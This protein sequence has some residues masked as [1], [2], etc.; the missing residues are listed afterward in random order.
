MRVALVCHYLMPHEGGI[1]RVVDRLGQEYRA[2]GCTTTVVGFG[3][4][5]HATAPAGHTRQALRGWN[6]LE[7]AGIPVPLVAPASSWLRLRQV[8]RDVDAV[9][10][11]GLLHPASTMA[12]VQCRR[13][14]L[15][16]VLTEHVGTVPVKNQLVEATQTRLIHATARMA[17][18]SVSALTVLNDRVRAEL[19]PLCH[20]LPVVKVPN[21]VD[22]ILFHPA[23]RDERDRLRRKWG[24]RRPTVLAVGRN[25]EKKHLATLQQAAEL[26][27]AFDL[28]VVGAGTSRLA[29]T[30]HL[31]RVCEWLAQ[32]ELA[33]LYR[34]ADLFVLPSTGEG[35]PL[36]VLEA[37]ASG[38]PAVIGNDGAVASELHGLP[39]TTVDPT[40]VRAIHAAARSYLSEGAPT[41]RFRADT[42]RA[43]MGRFSWAD[44]AQQYLELLDGA[45]PAAG[46][47]S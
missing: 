39:V 13:L 37:L 42:H 10:I 5:D 47:R 3:D 33:E 7:R 14:G 38:L 43:T 25:V 27:P 30:P 35:L 9:H 34:A 46:K 18:R 28:V 1:E 24:L 2:A 44:C 4:P 12:M 20:P 17:S 22:R 26:A 21:G 36:V 40:D 41:E 23:E 16:A 6:G 11:H 29:T 32:D 15:P 31:R 45:R 8:L 19:E